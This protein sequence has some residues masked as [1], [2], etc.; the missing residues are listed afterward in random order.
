LNQAEDAAWGGDL[1][2]SLPTGGQ[3]TLRDRLHHAKIRAKTGTLTSISALSGWV[4]SDHL[5]TW[6]EF[7]ILSSGTSKTTAS[8]IEDQIVKILQ[9]SAR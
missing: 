1:R 6:I 7:S 2:R 3:G 9:A 4:W 5:D 8:R